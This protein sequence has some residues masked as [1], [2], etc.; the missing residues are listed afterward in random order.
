MSSDS[1]CSKFA[2]IWRRTDS[3]LIPT[4][5]SCVYPLSLQCHISKTALKGEVMTG[6][7][8]ENAH[9]HC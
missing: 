8:F 3:E 7:E 5:D 2:M 9:R 4:G 1:D 6:M